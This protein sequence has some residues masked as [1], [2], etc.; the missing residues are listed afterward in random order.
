MDA[1]KSVSQPVGRPRWKG[2]TASSEDIQQLQICIGRWREPESR[3]HYALELRLKADIKAD[4]KTKTGLA[5]LLT[6]SP[7]YQ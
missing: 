7:W 6:D 1:G 4:I 2:H 5:C 3:S